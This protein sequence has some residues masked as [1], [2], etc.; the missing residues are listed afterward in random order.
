MKQPLTYRLKIHQYQY[1]RCNLQNID[2]KQIVDI[3]L[4]VWQERQAL[5]LEIR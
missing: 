2:D 4:F 5:P 3:I 1:W